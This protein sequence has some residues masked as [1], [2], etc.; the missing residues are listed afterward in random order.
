[1]RTTK[2]RESLEF[3]LSKVYPIVIHPAEDGYV[4]EIEELPG[5]MT[6]G[7]T[8]D[9]VVKRIEDA[10]RGWIE[11]AYED[12]QEIPLPRTDDEYSGR[13]VV[14]LPKSLHRRLAEAAIHEGVSLNQYVLSLLSRCVTLDVARDIQTQWERKLRDLQPPVWTSTAYTYC[15]RGGKVGTSSWVGTARDLTEITFEDIQGLSMIEKELAL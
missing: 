6:Q 10:R 4:A 3:Y 7:E 12:G 11:V 2:A 5:C 13:F 1:M 14:R 9:E 15:F 8:L